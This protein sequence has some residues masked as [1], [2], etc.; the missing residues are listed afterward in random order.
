[1]SAIEDFDEDGDEDLLLAIPEYLESGAVVAGGAAVV[2]SRSGETLVRVE[3]S[4]EHDKLGFAVAPIGDL[5]DDSRSEFLVGSLLSSE[6]K[7]FSGRAG[8]FVREFARVGN[9]MPHHYVAL[10]SKQTGLVAV[11]D[12]DV[13]RG[14]VVALIKSDGQVLH[15]LQDD[16]YG[17]RFGHSLAFI[18]GENPGK[19]PDV[20]I[21][22]PGQIKVS[23]LPMMPLGEG[24]PTGEENPGKVRLFSGETGEL[25]WEYS[26]GVSGDW[27][28]EAVC[29]LSDIDGDGISDCAALAQE[30]SDSPGIVVVLSGKTGAPILEARLPN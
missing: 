21:G 30:K 26:R 20:L 1:M 14:G 2:S 7:L 13:G 15:R 17:D 10:Y 3:S 9:G 18:L 8:A 4:K 5:D 25:L 12:P 23:G 11:S 22:A 24:E 16:H 28:G 6:L 29:G 19:A 27:F